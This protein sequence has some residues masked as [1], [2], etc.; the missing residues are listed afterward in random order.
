MPAYTF[1]HP[2]DFILDAEIELCD[3]ES[4]HALGVMRLTAGEEAFVL[5][6]RGSKAR[7]LIL[8]SKKRCRLKL[9]EIRR[10]EAMKTRQLH[11][12]QGLT[13]IAKADL[14]VEKLTELGIDDIGFFAAERSGRQ[15]FNEHQLQKLK[16]KAIQACKQSGRLWL[17]S[18]SWY[19]SLEE[20]LQIKKSITDHQW[21]TLDPHGQPWKE[22]FALLEKK[23]AYTLV[24]GPESGL[25]S[26]EIERLDQEQ[27]QRFNIHAN[28]LRAETAALA[29]ACLL[30]HYSTSTQ[31]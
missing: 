12:L 8:P 31:R 20:A 2:I 9:V 29:G 17:P 26:K 14:I 24:V 23:H 4:H 11:I 28:I 22:G 27:A 18:L 13:S 5:N 10:H 19:D 6:G 1:F 16:Q 25:A 7:G 3:E 30:E 21:I 15:T